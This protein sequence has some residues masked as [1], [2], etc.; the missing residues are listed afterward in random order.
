MVVVVDG[1]H[2][3]DH[4]AQQLS[5]G[6]ATKLERLG[7]LQQLV[8]AV[9]ADLLVVQ[10]AHGA[11]GLH[12]Q[13]LIAIAVESLGHEVRA[14]VF[15]QKPGRRHVDARVPSHQ[16]V[17]VLNAAV[18]LGRTQHVVLAHSVELE[19]PGLKAVRY[20]ELAGAHLFCDGVPR[21]GGLRA[22]AA[23]GS[24]H[25]DDL[26]ERGDGMVITIEVTL[27]RLSGRLNQL[28]HVDRRGLARGGATQRPEGEGTH[29]ALSH[30]GQ[31]IERAHHVL[32][33]ASLGHPGIDE[34]IAEVIGQRIG[35]HRRQALVCR[36]G[37]I[38]EQEGLAGLSKRHLQRRQLYA[39]LDPGGVVLECVVVLRGLQRN[40]AN[41]L[42]PGANLDRP[43]GDV[44][45]LARGLGFRFGS[46]HGFQFLRLTPCDLLA[47]WR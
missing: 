33:Q 31:A 1:Q 2:V 7:G 15:P 46:G 12:V 35:Q 21:N 18:A 17:G 20:I 16:V 19:Q 3:E 11:Q 4:S 40:C 36:L 30:V 29:P 39:S 24:A 43:H 41:Q 38:R 44:G 10:V 47:R 32:A 27:H 9:C 28:S 22:R 37:E 6:L 25:L 45:A 13:P 34:G 14:A 8:V 5:H 42:S 23:R 26:L